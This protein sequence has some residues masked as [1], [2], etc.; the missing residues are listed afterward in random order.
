[1]Y[2]YLAALSCSSRYLSR[3]DKMA[4]KAALTALKGKEQA[5]QEEIKKF[6]ALRKGQCQTSDAIQMLI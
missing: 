1:M 6:D 5:M 3:K 4:S 2:Q